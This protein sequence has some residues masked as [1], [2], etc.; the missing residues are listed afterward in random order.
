M[1][2]PAVLGTL[3]IGLNAERAE[4]ETLGRRLSKRAGHRERP[5][6][7]VALAN[8]LRRAA[9]LLDRPTVRETAEQAG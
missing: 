7:R 6:M 8:G 5:G 4:R 2:D 9:A 3:L 1:F